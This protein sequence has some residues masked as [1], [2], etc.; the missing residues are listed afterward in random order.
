MV[1]I[2]K[3]TVWL[4]EDKTTVLL[5]ALD[6]L[7]EGELHTRKEITVL[8][9][10]LQWVAKAN[11]QICPRLVGAEDPKEVPTWSPG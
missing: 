7:A 2:S 9:G 8:P 5:Q 4:P 10:R 3:L 11:L 1:G 6:K